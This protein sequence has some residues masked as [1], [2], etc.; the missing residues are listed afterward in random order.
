MIHVG[1][2]PFLE[3]E[4]T[5]YL[6]WLSKGLRTF[7]CFHNNKMSH[8]RL[9]H[10]PG[11]QRVKT[12]AEDKSAAA[13]LHPPWNANDSPGF[14]WKLFASEFVSSA[15][16]TARIAVLWFKLVRF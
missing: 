5:S 15:V 10:Q 8:V 12:I 7:M 4:M 3:C 1:P 2:L 13:N 16:K 6:S 14:T 11:P 9:P